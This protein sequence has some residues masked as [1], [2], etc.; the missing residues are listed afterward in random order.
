MAKRMKQHGMSM[1]PPNG[2]GGG[3]SRPKK[4]TPSGV[5]RV[6][7]TNEVST[8]D[9][10]SGSVFL[11]M[12]VVLTWGTIIK[13]ASVCV[14]P[15]IAGVSFAIYFFHKTN[16]HMEDPSIHLDRGERSKLET[17]IE[18]QVARKKL[19]KSIF[20]ELDIKT[21]ELKQDL[22]DQQKTQFKKLGAEIKREHGRQ[23]E[24]IITEVKK[25]RKDIKNSAY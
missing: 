1:A 23:F 14:L 19:E 18:A 11:P 24:K 15:L 16:I 21:R 7:S 6:T 22:G 17:K 8:G 25:T 2:G 9:D 4:R 20:S 3:R 13:F 10:F 12:P 5:V